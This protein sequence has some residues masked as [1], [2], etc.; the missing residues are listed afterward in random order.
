[1]PDQNDIQPLPTSLNIHQVS[2]FIPVFDGS[3][4]IQDFLQEV[5]DAQK[6]GAWP[7]SVTLKVAKSKLQGHIAEIV[8]TR[9]DLNHAQDFDTFA[10]RL[11]S[12]IHT[13]RPVSSRLQDLMTCVQHPSES[14]DAYAC[15]IRN[16]A[17]S[18]TEWDATPETLLLKN[19]T[20]TATFVKGLSAH[21]R[22][23][24]LP[25]NPSDFDAAITLAR[26]QELN[27][28]LL[29]SISQQPTA[30]SA[31]AEANDCITQLQCRVAS[32]EL[33]SAQHTQRGRGRQPLRR[34]FRQN[35][36]HYGRG[37]ARGYSTPPHDS[38]HQF[39]HSAPERYRSYSSYPPR[40]YSDSC[41]NCCSERRDRSSRF[42]DHSRDRDCD[43][44]RDSSR[45]RDSYRRSS[46]S[47]SRDRR[48]RSFSRSP[49]R[50]P[51][52]SRSDHY[53]RTQ[54]PNGYRSR[55]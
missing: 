48:G 5:R 3:F 28:S 30:S 22:Q 4:P 44:Y 35:Q 11:T 15:R 16:K 26:T 23:L 42:R 49:S 36:S 50:S 10:E 40:N 47:N 53:R 37:R 24:V 27:G 54:S 52:R 8:R 14:V 21:L 55:R 31:Q 1:M 29:P 20:V 32:L 45:H 51:D 33:A 43:R 18:L 17:K 12:A 7:D 13:D 39:H 46:R 34:N 9:N 25:H 2:S 38:R 6:L 19:R 41:R